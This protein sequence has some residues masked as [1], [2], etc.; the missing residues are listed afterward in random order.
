VSYVRVGSIL[1]RSQRRRRGRSVAGFGGIG[2]VF[3]LDRVSARSFAV[4]IAVL[5]VVGLLGFGL[6]SKGGPS[7]AVGDTPPDGSLPRLDGAGSARLSDYRGRW[8]LVNF[9]ASW[10]GPCKAES[11]VLERFYRL[12]RAH[13]FTVLGIDTRDLSGDGRAFVERYG[14]TYPQ[15]RDG[16]GSR[17][18]DFGASGVPENFLVSPQ[19]RL[20]FIRRGPVDRSYL[21]QFVAPLL[22]DSHADD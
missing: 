12:H 5:A 17:A 1:G 22:G 3:K 19:G 15:L 16:D 10:C 18:H 21:D 7:I 9:W 14:L 8:V 13:R 4:F 20:V 11:P 2:R 6:L